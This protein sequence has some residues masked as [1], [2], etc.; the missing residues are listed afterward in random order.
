MNFTY[1][2]LTLLNR[3]IG[4]ALMS[5]KIEFNEVSESVHK[6]V[7]D[8]IVKRNSPMEESEFITSE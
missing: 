2:E 8:E 6:K 3:M 4:I 5:G 7:A 1:K